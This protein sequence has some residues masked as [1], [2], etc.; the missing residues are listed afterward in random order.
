MAVL[1]GWRRRRAGASGATL[2]VVS[3]VLVGLALTNPGY[4]TADVQLHDSGVWVTRSN[5]LAAGRFNHEAKVIDAAV[6]VGSVDVDVLQR[7]DV[8]LTV[9]GDADTLGVVDTAAMT[10]ATVAVPDGALIRMGGPTVAL[11]DPASGALWAMPAAEVASFSAGET[12]PVLVLPDVSDLEV[13]LDGTVLLVSSASAQLV[14][15]PLAD[16]G[17][18]GE[19]VATT[20]EGLGADDDVV[21]TSVGSAAVV[22]NRTAGTVMLDGRSLALPGA[23][24]AVLQEPGPQSPSVAVAT[25]GALVMQPLDGSPATTTEVDGGAVPTSPV[26]VAG[27]TYAAWSASATVLRDC[28]GDAD[29]VEQQLPTVTGAGW[30]YRVNRGFVVLN[31]LADG[32]V[33][34]ADQDFAEIDDWEDALPSQQEAADEADPTTD[35]SEDPLTERDLPNR[36]PD[37]RDDDYGVRPGRTTILPVLD[38][39]TDPDG[40]VL[41]ATPGGEA[42][43][44]GVVQQVLHGSAVQVVVP[45]DATG[46]GTFGYLAD[47]GRGERDDATVTVTVHPMDVNGPPDAVR[48][49]VAAVESGSSVDVH[50]LGDWLD[51]DGDTLF[52]TGASAPEGDTVTFTADGTV[53][54]EDGGTATGRK[55]VTVQVSDGIGAPVE[56]QVQID[57]TERGLNVPPATRVDHVTTVVGREVAIEPLANDTDANGDD[58]RLARVDDA[59]GATLVRNLDAGT[60]TFSAP[61]VGTYYLLYLVTDGPHAALGLIRVDVVSAGSGTEPPVAVRDRALL[62]ADGAVLVDVLANDTDPAGGVLVVQ[63]VEVEARN[64]ISVAIVDH[65][66]LR[67]TASRIPDQPFTLTY[68]V[69]N[70]VSSAN[71]EVLV[72]PMPG[73]GSLQAPVAVDDEVTVRAGDVV[74]IDV[75]ENDTHPDGVALQLVPTLDETPDGAAGLIFTSA[76]VV[77]FQAGPVAQTVYA[78]YSVSDPQLNR[79]SAQITIHIKAADASDNAAPTPRGVTARMIAGSTLR[80]PIPLDGIDAD[81]D[82]VELIGLDRAPSLVRVSALG[83]GWVDVEAG[84]GVVGTDSFTYL[85]RDA[86]GA[87]A[88]GTV[89]VGIAPPGESNEAP[90]AVDDHLSVRPGRV[91]AVPALA[92]DIDAE[93]DPLRL[94]AGSLVGPE[95]ID[96]RIDVDRVVIS[97]PATALSFAVQYGV[98]DGFSTATGV[99]AVSVAADA[100]LALP[101]ARDDRLTLADVA[102][103]A[104]VDVDVLANDDDADGTRDALTVSTTAAGATVNGTSLRIGVL[105]TAQTIAYTATDAD[106]GTGTAFVHLPGTAGLRPTLTAGRPRLEVLSGSPLTIDLAEHVV[107]APDRALRITTAER[108][109]ALRGIAAVVDQDTLTYTSEPGYYGPASVTFQVIDTATVEDPAGRTATLSL[110]IDVLPDG[111]QPPVLTAPSVAVPIGQDTRIDLS[112]FAADP[113]GDPV[114]FSLSGEVPAGLTARIEGAELVVQPAEV[115]IGTRLRLGLSVTDGTNEPVVA[116]ATIRVV[117][118]S[119]SLATVVDDVIADANQGQTYE[120]HVLDNDLS[121]YADSSLHVSSARLESGDADVAVSGDVVAITPGSTFVGTLVVLYRVADKTGDPGREVEGRVNVTVRGVPD[122]PGTPTVVEVRSHTAVI[123]WSPPRNNGAEITGYRVDVSGSGSRECTATTCTIDGLVNARDYTFTVVATNAVGDS[124]PSPVSATIRPDAIPDPPT[125]PALTFGDGTLGVSWA[126]RDYSGDRSAISSVTLEISPAPPS[127]VAQL[128]LGSVT[129]ATWTGL[130]NG[131]AYRVRVLATNEAGPSEWGEYSAAEI[132]AGVPG[133]PGQPQTTM[134]DPVGAQ[135]QMNVTWSAPVSDNGDPVSSYTLVVRR[136]GAVVLALDLG[137]VLSQAVTVDTSETT[138]TYE[139]SATNK[140]GV[141]ATGPVSAPRQA[142]TKPGAVTGLS[143]TPADNAIQLAFSAAAGNGASAGQIRYVYSVN[144]AGAK[145]LAAD[146]RITGDVPNNG[147][148]T[149]AVWAIATVDGAEYVG[150]AVSANPAAPY[151]LPGVPGVGATASGASITFTWSP[152]GRNGRDI[153]AI[154]YSIDGGAAVTAGAGAGATA[155]SFGEGSTHCVTARA[156]DQAGQWGAWSGSACA[157][158]VTRNGWVSWGTPGPAAGSN[159][160]VLNVTDFPAGRYSVACWGTD[161][162]DG[163]FWTQSNVDVPAN[164]AVQLNCYYGI[165]RESVRLEVIGQY[166]TPWLAR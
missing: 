114:S 149:I 57:V 137:N 105:E 158:T 26:T 159:H 131:T 128:L 95:G 55:T 108:V 85:V 60:V 78:T 136:G 113:N 15:V 101:R 71:G 67:V 92:N 146:Q 72:V 9:N 44:V 8:V 1:A 119:A 140:A 94:V 35:E 107:V 124:A 152:P 90:V 59:P 16:A 116:Y 144:G 130:V 21:L 138:Y 106:G 110:P 80:I 148:Y 133:P 25:E 139:V 164:G 75:L 151:G 166:M 77:R 96:A 145:V 83:D 74:T 143:A 150:P 68:T 52:L 63:S 160:L 14:T 51:P 125:A 135:A 20:L 121:P 32:T 76:D 42:P 6:I 23:D 127:G 64:G 103:H 165:P 120:V 73:V 54:F 33:W 65:A 156:Q 84:R 102:G 13:G 99:V 36:P 45:P 29:D 48:E 7:D 89:L 53:T 162:T 82:S 70:G 56:G 157:T 41:A 163:V 12:E 11:W 126:N 2:S 37:A 141:G 31:S 18:P 10:S 122:A 98:S 47:D 5:D 86:V 111:D 19:P 97:T 40:D 66:F 154:Q 147:T 161:G 39:D 69:S 81:G 118:S 28:A 117:S 17:R 30:R 91:V 109:T 61:T 129:S 104:S 123:S 79:D 46:S 50:V 43:T 100:P 93:G 88:V 87:E 132:P 115:P 49:T 34:V 134:L 24:G 153:T 4:L 3:T 142:V 62:P 22:M 27:C 58:L 38:N 112:R 155:A